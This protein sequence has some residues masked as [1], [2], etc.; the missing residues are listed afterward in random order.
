[1]RPPTAIINQRRCPLLFDWLRKRGANP[2]AIAVDWRVWVDGSWLVVETDR[3][4]EYARVAT[5]GALSVRVVPL[6]RGTH[7]SAASGWQVALA[8]AE[9]DVLVG[10]PLPEWQVARDLAQRV[11][12]A[13]RLPMDEMT[14]KLFSR[15][16][17]I[18]F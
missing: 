14:E 16:G 7:H 3:Q 12:A 1:M 15:V 11:C 17:R 9:G 4:D 2:A 5:Q 18:K 6:T 8:C 10:Q 13:T